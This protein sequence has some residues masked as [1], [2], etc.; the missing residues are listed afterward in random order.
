MFKTNTQ[1]GDNDR[2]NKEKVWVLEILEKSYSSCNLIIHNKVFLKFKKTLTGWG[3]KNYPHIH[4][5]NTS[6]KVFI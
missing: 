6:N 2:K 4:T 3:F 1:L 5:T